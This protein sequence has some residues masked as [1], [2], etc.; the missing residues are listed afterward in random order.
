MLTLCADIGGTHTRLALTHDPQAGLSHIS[1]YLNADTDNL[2]TLVAAYLADK[3][4]PKRACFAVA[5]PTDGRT[6][7]L[8]NLPWNIDAEALTRQFKL[9][10][11]RLINDFQAVGY[12]LDTLYA[13]GLL[14]LQ[15][16]QAQPH[17]PK[18][19]LGPGT[20]LG[21]VQCIWNGQRHEPLPSEGGHIA[22]AP[23]DDE[24]I[25]LLK[26]L[27]TEY[28]RA[29]VERILSGTGISTL[30]QYCRQSAG[31]PINRPRSPAEVSHAALVGTD[32]AA[33]WAMDLFVRILG[34]T[35]G[36]LALI[37]QAQ[38]GIYL[39]GGIPAKILPWLK[40]GKLME[41]FKAKGRFSGWME[42]VP[43]H[44]VLDPDVGLKGAALAA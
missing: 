27:Q 19:A 13:D 42:T 11:A 24:Q 5:G 8:T 30:Y 35:A 18:V 32:P 6:A 10:H 16:G 7:S 43:V 15:P 26:F 20:G 31:R 34:Q 36:D 38:G 22:F 33:M 17:A 9:E 3:P 23:A 37:A 41:G 14:T 1:R 4:S 40:N 2:H 28:G 39:A 21:V 29:S 25:G 44:V 12:G